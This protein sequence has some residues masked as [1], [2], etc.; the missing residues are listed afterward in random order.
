[1]ADLAQISA[2]IVEAAGL[3][4]PLPLSVQPAELAERNAFA[5]TVAHLAGD[6]KRC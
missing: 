5:A 1:M 2:L 4:G 3:E 6:G